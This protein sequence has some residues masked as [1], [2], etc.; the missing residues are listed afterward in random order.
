MMI[1]AGEKAFCAGGDV[2]SLY[3]A[4][5]MGDVSLASNFF[6]KEYALDYLISTYR[7][8]IISIIDGITM[9]GGVG[10]SMHGR[11][12][13]ATDKTM[14]AMPET[15]LG[16]FPDVGASHF[17]T[18]AK[19]HSSDRSIALALYLGLTGKRLK[20]P[21][22]KQIGLATHIVK[23]ESVPMLIQDLKAILCRQGER[24]DDMICEAISM[25]SCHDMSSEED[26][27][28]RHSGAIERC[29]RY[30]TIEEIVNELELVTAQPGKS[31]DAE[32]ARSSLSALKAAAP[33]S[34]KVTLQQM[35]RACGLSRHEIFRM[36]YR[37][38]SRF[39]RGKSFYEGV[40][41]IL[42]DKD[43]SPKWDPATLEEVSDEDVKEY[44]AVPD[45]GDLDLDETRQEDFFNDAFNQAA[46]A[47]L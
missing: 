26:G 41:S 12:V 2:R 37:I 22:L 43:R 13:I 4:G 11:Y 27:I 1:G 6:K 14:F 3:D 40:R 8:P 19:L 7:K 23:S 18:R 25:Y 17:L 39:V 34:L 15:A 30:S 36:D 33:I 21:E 47:R 16:L 31:E 44:F 24:I 9:G 42:V 10:I 38:A 20:G 28:L 45:G 5:I 29:F 35:L 46:K 32:W